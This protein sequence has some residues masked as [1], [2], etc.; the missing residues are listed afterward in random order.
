[1]EVVQVDEYDVKAVKDDELMM[2]LVVVLEK[3]D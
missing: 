1:M 3:K 2:K